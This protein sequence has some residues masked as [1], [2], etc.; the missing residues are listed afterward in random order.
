MSKADIEVSVV[1]PAYNE[2]KYIENCLFSLLKSEQKTRVSYEVI[3]VDNNCSDAT[4]DIAKK[5]AAGMN[6][7]IVHEKRPGR[8]VARARGFEESFG[9]IILSADSDTVFYPLWIE[10]LTKALTG[11]IVAV[12]TSCKVAD[13]SPTTNWLFNLIQPASMVLYRVFLGHYW[14][15]GFSFGILKSIYEKSGGFDK[16]LQAQEDIDL[17]FRV[18]KLGRIRFI[19]KP[20]TFSGRRFKNNLFRGLGEYV[21]TFIQAFVFKRKDVYSDNPR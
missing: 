9:K 15:S 18:A 7:R 1:I 10:T 14:L 3:V 21:A 6:L 2:E 20:V 4:V 5:F 17:S 8:G 11:D 12:T 16:E 19:N 13:L